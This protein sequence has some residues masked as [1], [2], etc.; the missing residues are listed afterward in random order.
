M[1]ILNRVFTRALTCV[2]PY[3]AWTK[4]KP[5]LEHLRIFG[6]LAYMKAP[7]TNI[8]KLDDRGKVILNIGTEPSTKSYMLF[9]PTS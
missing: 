3:E 6:C 2:T 8:K 9:D 7:T 1:Y 4:R 5:S